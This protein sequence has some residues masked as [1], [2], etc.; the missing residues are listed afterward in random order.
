MPGMH[1]GHTKMPV[2]V[3][4]STQQV[5]DKSGVF[6]VGGAG[7]NLKLFFPLLV[8]RGKVK[9]NRWGS[10]KVLWTRWKE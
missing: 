7:A 5:G 3:Q 9:K 6:K 10:F 8:K 4:Y 1:A 2:R